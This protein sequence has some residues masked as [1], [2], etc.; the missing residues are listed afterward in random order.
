MILKPFFFSLG[1]VDASLEYLKQKVPTMKKGEELGCLAF[2]EMKIQEKA[3]WCRKM[4]AC[5]GPNKQA[6]VFMIRSLVGNWKLPIYIDFEPTKDPNEP[7]LPKGTIKPPK[8]PSFLL[9]QIIV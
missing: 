8:I 3:E 6:N 5:L 7:K 4:D 2:D 9:M 1:F